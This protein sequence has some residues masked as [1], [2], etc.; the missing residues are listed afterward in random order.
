MLT[1]YIGIVVCGFVLLVTRLD[2]T[3]LE[4]ETLVEEELNPQILTK[5]LLF[6]FDKNNDGFVD[7]EERIEA[8][9]QLDWE[10]AKETKY[11]LNQKQKEWDKKLNSSSSKT[12]PKIPGIIVPETPDLEEL[13]KRQLLDQ[14]LEQAEVNYERLYKKPEKDERKSPFEKK[15]LRT[16]P[17][18]LERKTDF[19]DRRSPFK[20]NSKNSLGDKS[21]KFQF[22][23]REKKTEVKNSAYEKAAAELIGESLDKYKRYDLNGD[24]KLSDEEKRAFL[25][26]K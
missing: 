24:G 23:S 2:S 16:Y 25:E 6:R 9:K 12:I 18:E 22:P 7:K 10:K 1:G 8:K 26:G 15:Q 21:D 5:E 11:R 3:E 4:E 13:A 17:T 14:E 20:P 19:W